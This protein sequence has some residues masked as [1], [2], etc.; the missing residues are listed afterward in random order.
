MNDNELLK[1]L[2]CCGQSLPTKRKAC[3]IPVSDCN[4]RRY[5]DI[6]KRAIEAINRQK[7]EIESLEMDVKQLKSDNIM[8]EQNFENIKEL[9]EAEKEK[10]EKAK[11]AAINYFKK[12]LSRYAY[13]TPCEI[14]DSVFVIDPANRGEKIIEYKV[15]AIKIN[16]FQ[17]CYELCI[18]RKNNGLIANSVWIALCELEEKVFLSRDEAEKALKERENK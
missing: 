6:K 1:A 16:E 8:A 2:E 11:Q 7:A 10:A 12:N 18:T 4:Y 13:I 9:Y 3:P 14:G 5:D 15:S 17:E